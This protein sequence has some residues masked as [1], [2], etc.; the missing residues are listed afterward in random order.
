[1]KKAVSSNRRRPS[2]ERDAEGD[3]VAAGSTH[4]FGHDADLFD[5]SA[6]GDVDD[7]DDFTVAQRTRAHDEQRL[8]LA[9]FEDAS[10]LLS[11]LAERDVLVVDRDLLVRRVIQ[12]DLAQ[13]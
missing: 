1:M 10:Q 6:L 3:L 7:F 4:A 13:I 2:E 9:L 12:D 8:L 5:A 11:E